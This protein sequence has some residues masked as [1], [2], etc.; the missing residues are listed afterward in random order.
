MTTKVV[1]KKAED[2]K[3]KTKSAL[4][5]GGYEAMV[6]QAIVTLAERNG[7]SPV[8]ILKAISTDHKDIPEDRLKLQVKMA[9]KRMTAKEKLVKVN[10]G[11]SSVSYLFSSSVWCDVLPLLLPCASFSTVPPEFVFRRCRNIR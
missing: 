11:R 2:A 3:G 4:P 7:S 6:S 1:K 9:L 5:A 10:A 8:A